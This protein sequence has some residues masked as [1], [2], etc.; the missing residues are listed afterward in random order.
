MFQDERVKT[1]SRA[2]TGHASAN[3]RSHYDRFSIVLHW[4]TAAI[5]LLQFALGHTWAFAP[6]PERYLMI[7][8]HMSFGIVLAAVL[9]VRIVWRTIPAHR[10][11]P[12][13]SGLMELASK[14]VHYLL[15]VLLVIEAVSGFV[16]RWSGNEAMSFFGLLIPA[17]FAPF[18][19]AA[20]GMIGEAHDLV[21]WAII[22]VAA[23]HALAALFHHYALRD[24]VLM[25]MLTSDPDA[26]DS[27]PRKR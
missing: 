17:P 9:A 27:Y 24:G 4:T 22:V 2:M 18:S 26:G 14:T 20:H 25:R 11:S 10:V 16:L 15:Y 21:A 7:V 6:K 8:T 12:A 1:T 19:Q 3:L 23:G 5:V 13:D